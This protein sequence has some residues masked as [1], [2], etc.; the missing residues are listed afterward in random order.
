[1]ENQTAGGHQ[2]Y[3]SRYDSRGMLQGLLRGMIRREGP[4]RRA[5]RKA[6]AFRTSQNMFLPRRRKKGLELLIL[7]WFVWCKI[8]TGVLVPS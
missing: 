1:M 6:L 3:D 4:D 5:L 7:V 8:Q 2:G